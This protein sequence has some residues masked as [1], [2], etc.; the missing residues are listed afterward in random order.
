M[1]V[2]PAIPSKDVPG[3]PGIRMR[4]R[5]R[6][7]KAGGQLE[8]FMPPRA[9]DSMPAYS[10]YEHGERLTRPEGA[11]ALRA[12]RRAWDE[13]VYYMRA[14]YDVRTLTLGVYDYILKP[15]QLEAW[16][17]WLRENAPPKPG[18]EFDSR[19]ARAKDALAAAKRAP[20]GVMY[21]DWSANA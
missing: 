3:L 8:G 20:E 4:Q 21:A 5:E 12:F 1:S 17:E 13:H 11:D 2:Q 14:T 18:A 9:D 7:S 6:M 16:A 15:I 19:N 10:L